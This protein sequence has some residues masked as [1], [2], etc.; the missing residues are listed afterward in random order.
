MELIKN[1][2]E[3]I[4]LILIVTIIISSQISAYADVPKPEALFVKMSQAY[5][6]VDFEGRFTMIFR[7]PMG[8]QSLDIQEYR[9]AP[10][11]RRIEIISPSDIAGLGMVVDGEE[12]WRLESNE[13]KH[14]PFRFLPP[15]HLEETQF[16]NFRLLLRN[17]K[18]G[19]FNGGS[20]AGRDTYL[21]EIT[22]KQQ[23]RPSRKLWIDAEKG[24]PLKSELYDTQKVLRRLIA[25]SKIDFNSAI[26]DKLFK[27]PRRF[28][29]TRKR[30]PGPKG[31]EIWN[32][33][34]SKVDINKLREKTQFD[35]VVIE[36]LP[37]GFAL[38]S[39]NTIEIDKAKNAHLKYSDGLTALSV[40][41]SP[42]DRPPDRGKPEGPPPPNREKQRNEPP[43]GPPPGPEKEEK[44]KIKG[45]DCIILV[46]GP[47]TII[48]W[49]KGGVYFT[50]ISELEKNDTIKIATDFIGK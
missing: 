8:S 40:F 32:Y 30:P 39:I 18:V 44:V 11:K 35:I 26:D 42:F 23:N 25:Y 12:R 13:K 41:Q 47:V 50:L 45:I 1:V 9:K 2:I 38:Q 34:Q 17:Y 20:V 14:L 7:L 5:Q 19:V 29:D 31:E 10:N 21:I 6:T 27:N 48:R 36:Q 15:E 3:K 49:N 16:Q 22:P 43:P 33:N 28:W 37:G 4:W 24:I 46:K